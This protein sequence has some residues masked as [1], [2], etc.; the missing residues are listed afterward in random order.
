[1]GKKPKSSKGAQKAK[2]RKLDRSTLPPP[3]KALNDEVRR[4]KLLSEL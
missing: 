4:R 2:E 1:M 3:P